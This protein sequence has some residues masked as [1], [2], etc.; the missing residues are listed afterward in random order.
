V[1]AINDVTGNH[2]SADAAAKKHGVT[3]FYAEGYAEW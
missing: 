2:L 1:D 3:S